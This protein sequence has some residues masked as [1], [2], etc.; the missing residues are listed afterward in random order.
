MIISTSIAFS[1]PSLP[2]SFL[3]ISTPTYLP[4][5][6]PLSP[7]ALT[8]PNPYTG[9]VFTSGHSRSE[10]WHN[11]SSKTRTYA[12][13][14]LTDPTTPSRPVLSR[15]ML[16]GSGVAT[17]GVTSSMSTPSTPYVKSAA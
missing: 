3:S 8:P 14:R 10:P 16:E 15:A 11:L 2:T 1:A 13:R 5:Q 9:K 7:G 12:K 4:T 17:G 6:Q